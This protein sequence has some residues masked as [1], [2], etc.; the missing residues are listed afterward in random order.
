MGK[1]DG[2][3]EKATG[4]CKGKTQ[5]RLGQEEAESES[6]IEIEIE[7]EL[8]ALTL[9]KGAG[10]Q[11]CFIGGVPCAVRCARGVDVRGKEQRG[12]GTWSGAP[13]LVGLVG[14]VLVGKSETLLQLYFPLG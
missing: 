14:V 2:C 6:E 12:R 1:A 7:S 4:W 11:Y 10:G 3:V 5:T 8:G 13:F 9:R